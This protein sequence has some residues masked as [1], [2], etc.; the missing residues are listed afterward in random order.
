MHQKK[1]SPYL[2][3][4]VF[5]SACVFDIPNLFLNVIGISTILK[6]FSIPIIVIKIANNP[7]L[8]PIITFEE[9]NIIG[10]L[11]SSV[12]EIIAESGKSVKFKRIG[13]P[14]TFSH[15]VGQHEY[16]RKMFGLLEKP[17]IDFLK[18]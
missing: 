18:H 12:A 9:H 2:K 11:G 5:L 10:G 17:S 4:L 7:L 8:L 6:L 3:A 14:D 16:Q 1:F 15:Y 13:L